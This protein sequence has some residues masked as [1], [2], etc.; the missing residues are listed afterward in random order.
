[1]INKIV[2]PGRTGRQ[3]KLQVLP[4]DIILALAAL[5]LKDRFS[6]GKKE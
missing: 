1:M 2:S 4:V 5:A 3:L 6:F